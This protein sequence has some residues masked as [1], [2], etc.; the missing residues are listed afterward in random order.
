MIFV[1]S[2]NLDPR[3]ASLNTEVGIVFEVPDLAAQ[4]VEG[5]QTKAI[6]NS[7]QVEFVPGPGGCKECGSV[8]W[9]LEEDGRTQRFRREPEA[10]FGRRCLV[11]LLSLLPIES[12]L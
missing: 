7:Y 8:N 2:L 3:S 6:G 12:Q 11:E 1:G 9:V 5:I 4:M 10:S